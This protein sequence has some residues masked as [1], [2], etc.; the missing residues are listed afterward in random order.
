MTNLTHNSFFLYVYFSSLHILSNPVLIIRRINSIK[1]TSGTCHSERVTSSKQVRKKIPDLNTRWSPTQSDIYQ[2]KFWYYWFSSWWAQHC[3]K[4]VENWN[5]HIRKKNCV[6]SWS[7][8][9]IKPTANYGNFTTSKRA[10]GTHW[11]EILVCPRISVDA[12]MKSNIHT[13]NGTLTVQPVSI[14]TANSAV[15]VHTLK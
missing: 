10:Q 8:T 12:P 11:M 15:L 7:L 9:R 14:H 4:Y 6:S 13:V 2:M 5:K 1:T 3:S